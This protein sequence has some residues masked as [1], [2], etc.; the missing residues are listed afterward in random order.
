MPTINKVS[1]PPKPLVPRKRVAA[2]ARVSMETDALMHSL[3]AQISHYSTLIQANPEWDY[4]G[5]YADEGITGTSTKHRT[6]FQRLLADCEAGRIDLILVKSISRFARDTLDC[7]RT[8]RR[9]KAIHVEVQFE[10]EGISTFSTE[11]E[12]L[13][14]L[15]AAF[16]QAESESISD[17]TKWAVRSRFKDGIPNGHK[18]PYGYR[19]DGTMFRIIPDQ[20]AVVRYIFQQYLAGAPAYAV[21]KA[22]NAKG[23]L[24][25]CGPVSDSTV[26]DILSNASYT[27]TMILQKNYQAGH[28]RKHNRGELTRYA[29][30][31]I[32]E[33][34][35]SPA[36]YEHV[37]AIRQQRAAALP[38]PTSTQFTGLI[39][40]GYCS[41]GISRRT[42]RTYKEWRCNTRER[43]QKCD[44]RPILE[45]EL[46]AAADSVC[47][48]EEFRTKVQ[49]VV[50]YGD[51]IEFHLANKVK[52]V[53]RRYDYYN[54]KSAFSD[55]LFCG[56][57][58]SKLA[59]DTIKHRDGSI[60]I[61]WGCTR[62]GCKLRLPEPA[63]LEA[64]ALVLGT[65]NC[66]PAFVEHI[67]RAIVLTDSIQF[68]FKD[69]R[70]KSCREQY[71]QSPQH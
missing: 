49:Q 51:R 32:L 5:V 65:D 3:A 6:E 10:R 27:G 38:T 70:I 57:C 69:G 58:G 11:G 50:L 63:L 46:I 52:A 17:N 15:L 2:Y 14:T 47:P 45:S 29:V 16:A 48:A 24:G 20:A 19:W 7:L 1:F 30:D 44:M 22:V 28:T 64:S 21:A 18:A 42:R 60:H 56:L 12:L 23:L 41:R 54:R 33:P 36:D 55:H 68:E 35:I 59:R 43:H 31:G 66:Q 25:P 37:Q 4:A 39:K 34:L 67:R 62:Q 13:L 8:I 26:K 40:C 53:P 71:G 9:L 61:S